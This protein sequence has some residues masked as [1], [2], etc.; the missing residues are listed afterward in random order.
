[1]LCGMYANPASTSGCILSLYIVFIGILSLGHADA[2]SGEIIGLVDTGVDSTHCMLSQEAFAFPCFD[3]ESAT[4]VGTMIDPLCSASRFVAMLTNPDFRAMV[5]G[6]SALRSSA[7]AATSAAS[8]GRLL[9][10][11]S[12]AGVPSSRPPL[13][14]SLGID[15]EEREARFVSVV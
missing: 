14:A 11:G 13:D 2:G 8:P 3:R 7:A 10:F 9:D 1:M 4:Q 15:R 5:S 12:T 6:F